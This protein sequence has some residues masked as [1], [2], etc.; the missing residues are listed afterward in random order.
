MEWLKK[1]N[2][3]VVDRGFPNSLAY[4]YLMSY[5]TYMPPFLNK[6]TKQYPTDI[7]IQNRFVT[8]V[9]WITDSANGCIKQWRIFHNVLPN[10][11]LKKPDDL[12]AIV[13][14]LQ[15]CCGTLLIQYVSKDKEVAK[16][17]L[18][19]LDETNQPGNYVTKLENKSEKLVR[20]KNLNATDAALEF[21][22]LTFEELNALTLGEL[23]DHLYMFLRNVVC[24]FHE[25][26]C[27][28]RQSRTL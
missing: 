12:I 13:C 20:W 8:K 28:N 1:G 17:T 19:L 5:Q 4:L 23:I 27:L 14:A 21:P 22:R 18:R 10:S 24:I 7:A 6:G 16:K 25:F 2:I 11:L 15:D 9:R 26:T 3:L